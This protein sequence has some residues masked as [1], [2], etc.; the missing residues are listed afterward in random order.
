MTQYDAWVKQETDKIH[1]E[2]EAKREE[3]F[4]K[5]FL[6]G[7]SG[8]NKKDEDV[9]SVSAQYKELDKQEQASINEFM[10]QIQSQ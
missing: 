1:N 9:K 5:A 4:G 6:A 8:K 10:S 2:Y 3:L 7:M